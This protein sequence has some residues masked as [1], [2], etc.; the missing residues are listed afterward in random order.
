MLA[1]LKSTYR[2]NT[3]IAFSGREYT[4]KEWRHVPDEFAENARSHPA[5]ELTDDKSLPIGSE[6]VEMD[7]ETQLPVVVADED[8]DVGDQPG[9]DESP[10]TDDQPEAGIDNAGNKKP[11]GRRSRNK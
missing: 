5:L 11:N 2:W 10:D 3:L 6:Y 8:T 9:T 4:K 1:R 7:P